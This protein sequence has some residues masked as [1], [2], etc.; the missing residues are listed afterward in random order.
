MR[1]PLIAA[2][3][4]VALVAGCGDEEEPA[5]STGTPLDEVE[6]SGDAGEKPTLDFEQPLELTETTTRVL[7]EG[8]GDEIATGSLVTFD[9]VFVN[10]RD[11]KE[12]DTSYD[13]EPAELVYEDSLMAGVYKGLDRVP[14][15]S[16]VLVGIAPDDGLGADP[17]QDV[18]ETDTLLFFA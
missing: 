2:L 14:A 17:T 13:K 3:V 18:R 11:G 9:Y 16:R 8:D 10:G 12:L 4:A 6:V 1:R 7:E 15:G 5:S